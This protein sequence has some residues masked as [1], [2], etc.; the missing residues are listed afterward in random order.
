MLRLISI[1]LLIFCNHSGFSQENP[2]DQ[3]KWKDFFK[4]QAYEEK[5]VAIN[6]KTFWDLDGTYNY[7]SNYPL[8]LIY[9]DG[10][11]KEIEFQ[12]EGLHQLIYK[13]APIQ[14][15]NLDKISKDGVAYMVFDGLLLRNSDAESTVSGD[16]F[17]VYKKGPLSLYR[18]FYTSPIQ[19]DLVESALV[20]YYMGELVENFYLGKFSK[21]TSKLLADFQDL[22]AKIRNERAGYTDTEKDFLRIASE[23]NVWVKENAPYKY[24]DHMAMF[25]QQA[26][27]LRTGN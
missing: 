11:A 9:V 22:S 25:W 18:E 13:E 5:A 1:L 6:D 24:D 10:T 4:T 12:F 15:E 2:L 16:F 26:A 7:Y 14:L 23:Y 19:R 20:P 17:I 21:K 3:E 8:L 27:Y